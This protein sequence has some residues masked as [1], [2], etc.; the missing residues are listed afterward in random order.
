MPSFRLLPDVDLDALVDYVI[1]LS[2]RGQTER[3][4]LRQVAQQL[5]YDQGDRLLDAEWQASNRP[6]WDAAIAKISQLADGYFASW[7][8]SPPD[9]AKPPSQMPM[10]GDDAQRPVA[11][12]LAESVQR[13]EKLFRSAQANCSKCHGDD[14]KGV[15]SLIDYDSWTKDW[16]VG[17]GF[18]RADS[19]RM[20][21]MLKA[22]GL[23]PL[24]MKPR[25]LTLGALR[26]GRDPRAVY[27]RL[28][29]GIEGTSMPG[30]ALQPHVA[31][32]L[33][34]EQVWD[35][36]NFVLSLSAG[37]EQSATRS[38]QL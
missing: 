16:T 21:P 10:W 34:Q 36:V 15:K 13:G 35:L 28:V 14:G 33:T 2:V 23:K 8:V 19:D 4:L 18:D 12:E 24:P 20:R 5:D 32:G 30:L 22:S 6:R 27:L 3:E 17:L 31:E 11:P 37:R 1:F 38:G 7:Q 26:G 25:D 9:E 29:N